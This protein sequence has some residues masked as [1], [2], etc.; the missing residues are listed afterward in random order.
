MT[1]DNRV[2]KIKQAG[3][4][5]A[6]G[7]GFPTYRKLESPVNDIIANGAECEPLL[8]KD[9]ESMVHEMETMFRGLKSMQEMTSARRVTIALKEKNRNLEKRFQPLVDS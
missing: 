7:A 3:V 2:F 6:G 5:G 4:I 1:Q 9:R 8:A